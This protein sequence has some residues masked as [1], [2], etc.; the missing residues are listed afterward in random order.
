[1][2]KV[3]PDF[4]SVPLDLP[5]VAPE[6]TAFSDSDQIGP[7]LLVRKLGEGGVGVVYLA[8]DNAQRRDVAVKVLLEKHAHDK[9]FAARFKRDVRAAAQLDHPNVVKIY[10]VEE[11]AGRLF[12]AMEYCEGD[13]LDALLQRCAHFTVKEALD[14]C[15]QT[16][17][18]LQNAHDNGFVHRDIKPANLF[19]CKGGLV[20]ILDFGT[21]RDFS[22]PDPG[23]VT[24]T[25]TILH[26]G[27][28][29]DTAY[30]ISPEYARADA[31]IDGRS[32]I[33]SLGATFFHLLTG[34][35]PFQGPTPATVVLKHLY[36]DPP[37]VR[38][39]Q[40]DIPDGVAFV[41][42]R[43]MAK[44]PQQRY[45]GCADLVCDLERLRDGKQPLVATNTQ[46][47]EPARVSKTDVLPKKSGSGRWLSAA[48]GLIARVLSGKHD[49]AKS[50]AAGAGDAS[51]DAGSAASKSGS[52]GSH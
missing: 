29:R 49:V 32:D 12:F 51:Q 28:T 37:D 13:P 10:A 22:E 3:S 48:G 20:K 33:Y 40:H 47:A 39:L 18:G 36:E 9:R 45:T 31:N 50:S 11:H 34:R 42:A 8:Q 44:D 35:T 27:T 30:Y 7:Y 1:M 15:I 46:S 23:L 17:W 52:H 5:A 24:Q 16:A 6:E 38:S 19:V 41:V 26:V 14:V 2:S 21:W 4:A 43:M 25:G